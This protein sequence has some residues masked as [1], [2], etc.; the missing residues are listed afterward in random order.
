[1]DKQTVLI[2][3]SK[4]PIPGQVK[5]RLIQDFGKSYS[6]TIYRRLLWN[7]LAKAQHVNASQ[8]QLYIDGNDQHPELCRVTQQFDVEIFQQQGKDLVKSTREKE[9]SE[10]IV[11]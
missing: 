2:I 8:I 1:M 3:F 10:T 9:E 6:A 7:T 5:T 4:V 11:G